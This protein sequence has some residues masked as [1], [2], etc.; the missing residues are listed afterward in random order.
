MDLIV[1]EECYIRYPDFEKGVIIDEQI[2]IF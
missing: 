2:N 1:L